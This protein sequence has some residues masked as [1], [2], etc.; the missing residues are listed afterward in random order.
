MSGQA[1]LNFGK[2]QISRPSLDKDGM[3]TQ[4]L[5]SEGVDDLIKNG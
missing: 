5:T 3:G 2:D 1:L 4:F